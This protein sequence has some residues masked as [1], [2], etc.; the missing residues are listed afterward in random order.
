MCMMTSPT[1]SVHQL[2]HCRPAGMVS[3]DAAGGVRLCGEIE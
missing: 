2:G 1:G 3:A